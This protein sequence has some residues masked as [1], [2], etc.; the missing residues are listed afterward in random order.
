MESLKN[1][2]LRFQEAYDIYKVLMLQTG[3][4]PKTLLMVLPLLESPE[5]AA[6]LLS[7]ATKDNRIHIANVK[8][9]AGVSI[10]PLLGNINGYYCLNLSNELDR[11]CFA[12]LLGHSQSLNAL[13][14]T[15]S[16][17]GNISNDLHNIGD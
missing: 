15:S 7:I 6:K 5:D 10:K 8:A 2:K 4:M 13:R 3:N 11:V 12:R 1:M 16:Q 17:S 9:M 14:M